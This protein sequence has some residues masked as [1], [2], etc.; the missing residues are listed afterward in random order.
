MIKQWYAVISPEMMEVFPITDDGRGPTEYFRCV[1]AVHARCPIEAKVKAVRKN[2]FK[3][4][5]EQQ[6]K[7]DCS[8]YEGLKVKRI[9]KRGDEWKC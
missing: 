8:P 5:R 9:K 3:D 1:T 2:A 4:W 6:E 7:D